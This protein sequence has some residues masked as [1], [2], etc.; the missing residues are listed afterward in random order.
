[1]TTLIIYIT[2]NTLIFTAAMVI[3]KEGIGDLKDAANEGIQKVGIVPTSAIIVLTVT[4]MM[5][6]IIIFGVIYEIIKKK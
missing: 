2:I 1:M 5:I 3:H 4:I 6:P